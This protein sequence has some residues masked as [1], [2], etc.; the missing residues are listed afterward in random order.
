MSSGGDFSDWY[1]NIPLVTKYWFTGS[2]IVPLV[3]R[4]GIISAQSL[5]LMYDLVF[6]KFQVCINCLN[7]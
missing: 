5:I 6:Q 7:S 3:A 2:V 4:F 1:K